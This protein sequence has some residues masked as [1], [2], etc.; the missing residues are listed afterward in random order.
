MAKTCP[1][2]GY[3]EVETDECPRCGVSIPRDQAAVQG[4]KEA[5]MGIS[6]EAEIPPTTGRGGDHQEKRIPFLAAPRVLIRLWKEHP[7]IFFWASFLLLPFFFMWVG[8]LLHDLLSPIIPTLFGVDL[9]SFFLWLF[10]FLWIVTCILSLA[11]EWRA[12]QGSRP[13]HQSPRSAGAMREKSSRSALIVS[14]VL[15]IMA[16]T[17]MSP[18]GALAFAFLMAVFALV[19][20]V[21]GPWRYRGIGIVAVL[22]AVAVGSSAFSRGALQGHGQLRSKYARAASD[23]K[24]A[25]TQVVVYEYDNGVYPTSLKVLRDAGYANVL[26]TDPWSQ[27]YV[28]APVLTS[29]AKPRDGDDVYIHSKG[30]K[31]T[32]TYPRPFIS[33]TGENGSVGYSSVYGSFQGH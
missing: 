6:P 7:R 29:G 31:G 26:D 16:L 3:A 1:K 24:T 5:P 9:H 14:A 32:G 12:S 21:C 25:V 2:C 28:L 22:L 23:T 13:G 20:I 11:P 33:N 15:L 8:G 4:A 17:V 27:P 10:L 19:P 18:D 30:P